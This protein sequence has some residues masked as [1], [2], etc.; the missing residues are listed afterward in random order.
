MTDWF[1]QYQESPE[2]ENIWN[3]AYRIRAQVDLYMPGSEWNDRYEPDRSI[4]ESYNSKNGITL[5]EL[6][7]SAMN[8][9][10]M[11]LDI[12]F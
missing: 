6:Q 2:F 11:I 9:L 3:N 4:V 5:G 7:R 10:K 1:I 8:I 12:K